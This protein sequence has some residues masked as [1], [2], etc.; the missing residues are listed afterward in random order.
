MASRIVPGLKLRAFWDF[1]ESGWKSGMDD[2]LWRLS[3]LVQPRFIDFVTELP[4]TPSNGD[5][6]I[7]L[8][9]DDDQH[10]HIFAFDDGDWLVLEPEDKF[11]MLNQTNGQLSVF[12]ADSGAWN[13]LNSPEAI[14]AAY[15]ANADTNAFTDA[16]K[17]KLAGVE[18]NATADMSNAE[19]KAAYEANLNTNAFTDS[20]KAKLAGLSASRFLGVY[21]T[22]TALNAAHPSP[23]EG[24]FAYV[25][26]GVGIDIRVYIW[27]ATDNKFVPQTGANSFETPETIK[28]KYETNDDTN[29]FTDAYKGMLDTLATDLSGKMDVDAEIPWTQITDTPAFFSGSWN[30]LTDLPSAF[31][32]S[33]HTHS[34]NDLTDLPVAAAVEWD[35]IENKPTSFPPSS[36]THSYADLTDLP[37]LSVG[38]DDVLDKPSTFPPSAHTHAYGDL[39]GLP[40]LF[41]GSWNDLTDKPST[42]APSAHSHADATTSVAGF[43]SASDK[44]KLDTLSNVMTISTY[45]ADHILVLGNASSYV[46]MDLSV[47]GAVTVPPNSDVA[48]AVGTSIQIRA[49]GSGLVSVLAGSGVT[50]NTPE[51]LNL[52]KQHSTASLIKV[53]TDEWD[54]VGDLEIAP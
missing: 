28:L 38:W 27:D 2:N 41:S 26:T 40:S 48:F 24:S 51:T 31:P 19:I 20:E 29:A 49:A 54:L 11:L 33:T 13:P 39:T 43:M 42:F 7:L 8:D 5:I 22:L 21:P 9:E 45:T 34:Y 4:A 36:H 6:Y 53:A 35:D 37:D 12:Y 1:R 15:E 16:E 17:T 46:R 18:N 44:T 10:N 25:D 47:D 52:R 14:K 32:P 30:D 3:L 50:V 23:S